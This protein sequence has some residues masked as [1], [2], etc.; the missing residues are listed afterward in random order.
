MNKQKDI[1]R[2]RPVRPSFKNPAADALKIAGQVV[3]Y[4]RKNANIKTK[5]WHIEDTLRFQQ[6]LEKEIKRISIYGK[7]TRYLIRPG[8]IKNFFT[9]CKPL[10]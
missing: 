6:H 8:D 4:W 1:N 2:Q 10:I 7:N 9:M 3:N 5:N